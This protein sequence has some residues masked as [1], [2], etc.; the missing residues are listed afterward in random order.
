MPSHK[1][2]AAAPAVEDPRQHLPLNHM[3]SYTY[4]SNCMIILPALFLLTGIH[5]T[6]CVLKLAPFF[7]QALP[8]RRRA[9]STAHR[10]LPAED[11][12]MFNFSS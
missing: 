2:P 8:K 3:A 5:F 11:P 7:L 4:I 10:L 9:S 1:R 6:S 12:L